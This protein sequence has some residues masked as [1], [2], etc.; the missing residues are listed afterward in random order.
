MSGRSCVRFP[1]GYFFSFDGSGVVNKYC[2]GWVRCRDF[3]GM[4]VRMGSDGV[5]EE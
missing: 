2:A 3:P 4:T 1:E 5:T